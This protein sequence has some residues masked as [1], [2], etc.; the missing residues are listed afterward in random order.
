M[1]GEFVGLKVVVDCRSEFV[2]MGTLV[3]FDDAFLE[4]KD[5]DLH[6]L[7]DTRTDRENYV[8]ASVRTGVKRNRKRVLVSRADVTAVALLVDVTE[9]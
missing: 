3:R 6:D 4:L 9:E 5:A 8:V 1:L 7:R 2:A